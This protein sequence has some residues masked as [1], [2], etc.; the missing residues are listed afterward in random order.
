LFVADRGRDGARTRPRGAQSRLHVVIAVAAGL[1]RIDPHR[2]LPRQP[3]RRRDPRIGALELD[4][5]G[6]PLRRKLEIRGGGLQEIGDHRNG[7]LRAEG[8]VRL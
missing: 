3:R 6:R 5:L 4:F 1:E 7:F 8:L 2:L